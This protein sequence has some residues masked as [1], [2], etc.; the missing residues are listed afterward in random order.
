MDAAVIDRFGGVDELYMR[1]M[2][3]P[4]VG[5]DD[6]LIQVQAAAAGAWDAVEREGEYDG[7]FGFESTFPY[8]LGWDGAGE[9]V[10]IGKNVSRF[11]LGDRVYAASMPLPRG[12]FYAQYAVVAAE[13]VA[14]IPKRLTK[15]QAGVMGW[16]ALTA[17][18]GLDAL[19]LRPGE[20]LMIF[21]AS[22]GIGHMAVQLAHHMGIRVFAVASGDDGVALARR[23]GAEAV[24]NGRRDD[25]EAAAREFSPS[26]LD[27]AIVLVGGE[28][29]DRALRVLKADA[30]VACP[31][32]VLPEPTVPDGVQLFMYNGDR[33]QTATDRLNAIIDSSSFEVHIDRTFPLSEVVEAHRTLGTHYVGKLVLLPRHDD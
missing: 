11:K 15:E 9:V 26:G 19:A 23:L 24:V 2:P 28:A 21:G 3:V 32:G 17:L 7:V 12:G 14:H 16:D 25:V 1:K 8:I 10:E 13:H 30:R 33:T 27:A 31:Y 22:G 6:V 18:S 5:D 20:T 29:S 4:Q